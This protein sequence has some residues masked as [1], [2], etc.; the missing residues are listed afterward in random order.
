[1]TVQP[2]RSEPADD[3]DLEIE[4]LV[5]AIYRKYSYDFRHYA[6]ASMRRR[7]LTAVA[8]L[9]IE[10]VSI[11]QH[12]ILREP[13]LFTTLLTQLTVPVSELFRDPAYFRALREHV[14]PVLATYP[15]LKVWVAGCSTGEEV[16]SLAILLDESGLLDRT[17]VYATDLNP[18]SLRVAEAGVF[19]IERVAAFTRNYQRA[20]GARSLADYY[21]A[22]YGGVVFDR[23]LRARVTF[24]D[25]CLATDQVFAEVHLVSCRNVLIYFDRELQDHAIG[26]FAAAL[27]PRGYLGLGAHE[28]LDW[29]KYRADFEDAAASERIYRRKRLT[30]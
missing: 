28:R 5:E 19:S 3:V 30:A 6:R 24:S 2:H 25:H 12:R 22:A 10:S 23:R 21:T 14:L 15:S 8:R 4:L 13:A 7:V 1:M 20:S 9:G 27:A 11:L 16:Y 18:E 29:S 17:I 26:L